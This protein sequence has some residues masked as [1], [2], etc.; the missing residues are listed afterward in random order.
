MRETGNIWSLKLEIGNVR[1]II[2]CSEIL[3]GGVSYRIEISQFICIPKQL[4]CFCIA[5]VSAEGDYR[6][7]FN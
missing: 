5:R 1:V 6:I 3:F 2:A 7:D 4:T